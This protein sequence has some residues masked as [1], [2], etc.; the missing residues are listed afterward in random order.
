MQ[1][2]T[3]DF[4]IIILTNFVTLHRQEENFHLEFLNQIFQKIYG[5]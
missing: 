2:N 3:N 4:K 1:S 5:Q